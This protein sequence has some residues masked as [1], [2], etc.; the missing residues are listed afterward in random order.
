MTPLMYKANLTGMAESF[1]K[2][3]LD[4]MLAYS[5]FNI[6]W[7]DVLQVSDDR[8][9]HT[10]DVHDCSTNPSSSYIKFYVLQRL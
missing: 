3:I 1:D 8:N 6:C 2:W 10:D 4:K 9:D 5:W 7:S